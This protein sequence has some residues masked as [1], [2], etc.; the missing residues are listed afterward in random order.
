M[1]EWRLVGRAIEQHIALSSHAFGI[2]TQHVIGGRSL[3]L[4]FNSVNKFSIGYSEHTRSYTVFGAPDV[5]LSRSDIDKDTYLRVEEKIKTLSEKGTRLLG[6]ARVKEGQ[7]RLIEEEGA[8]PEYAKNLEFLGVLVLFDPVRKDVPEAIQ[9]IERDGVR[10]VIVTGD[11][12]GTAAAVARELGWTVHEEHILT[13]KDIRGM[14]DEELLPLLRTVSV[15][16]RMTPEDKLR[17]AKLFQKQGEVVAM[18]GDGVNDAPSLKAADV[19]IAVGSGS[20]VAKSAADLILLDDGFD[21]IVA[22][23]EEGRRIIANIRKTFVY[24]LV[25]GFDEVILIGGALLFGLPLPLSALQIIWVNFLV[26]GLPALSFAFEKNRDVET[27]GSKSAEKSILTDEVRTLVFGL[28]LLTSFCLFGLYASLLGVGLP[29]DL[30]RS[31]LFLCFASYA[32]AIAFSLKSLHQP[33]SSYSPFSNR[34]LNIGVGLGAVIIMLSVTVPFLREIFGLVEV[35]L[36]YY[37]IVFLWMLVNVLL[38][39]AVKWWFRKNSSIVSTP[40]NLPV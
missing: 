38:I 6:V 34:I 11:L 20:D 30:A 26:E 16:A 24:L 25:C 22:A 4:P 35:P 14:K 21:I 8:K 7:A 15:F 28:G 5:L 23:I 12:P 1:P 10:V 39:E 40:L 18:T 19:G 17:I 37:T 31:I 32:V 36:P 13:G 9:R 2:D 3:A 27:R 33:L 29:E